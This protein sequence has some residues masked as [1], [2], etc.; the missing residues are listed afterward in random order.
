[1]FIL[2]LSVF[3]PVYNEEAILERN[4]GRVVKA[5]SGLDFEVFIVDDASTDGSSAIGK[6]LA[7]SDGRVSYL[8]FGNGPSRRENLAASFSKAS[9]DAVAFIDADLS[10]GPEYLPE[11]AGLLGG[12]DVV[13]GSKFMPDSSVSRGIMR[14]LFTALAASFTRLYFGCSIKDYQCGL[15]VFKKNALLALVGD[16]GYDSSLRRG[17]AWDTEI[18]VR[19][20]RRGFRV[21]EFPVRWVE[22]EKSSVRI[23]RDWKMVPYVLRLRFRL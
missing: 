3:I 10:A 12:A 15:K 19:A 16:A 13:V 5:L 9:G 2:M 6:R 22:A 20:C 11:M 7:A 23:F 18:L 1:L 14:R 17:F 21:V 4:V 8:R